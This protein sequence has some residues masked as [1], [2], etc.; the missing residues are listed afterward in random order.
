VEDL[1]PTDPE[2][3]LPEPWR[4]PRPRPDARRLDDF[5]AGELA[6]LT[7]AAEDDEVVTVRRR[8]EP[9]PASQPTAEWRSWV[10]RRAA[11]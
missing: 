7:P 8:G 11:R 4:N 10:E 6:E 5:V 2:T 1:M 3:H 9:M